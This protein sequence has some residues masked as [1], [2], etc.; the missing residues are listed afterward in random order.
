[1]SSSQNFIQPEGSF[2]CSLAFVKSLCLETDKRVPRH[3]TRN[4]RLIF[5]SSIHARLRL[6]SKTLSSR[7][8]TQCPIHHPTHPPVLNHPNYIQW[9]FQIVQPLL[10]ILLHSLVTS[11]F[12]VP[13]SSSASF[14]RT[15]SASHSHPYKSTGSCVATTHVMWYKFIICY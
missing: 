8:P 6:L 15:T 1:M 11:S 14:P 2:P 7:F 4:L 12:L 3:L 10:C 13:N 9:K 5:I